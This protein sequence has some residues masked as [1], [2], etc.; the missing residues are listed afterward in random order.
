MHNCT[1]AFDRGVQRRE[2]RG[3]RCKVICTTLLSLLILAVPVYSRWNND[4]AQRR[5]AIYSGYTRQVRIREVRC[6]VPF[7]RRRRGREMYPSGIRLLY[8]AWV[9][10]SASVLVKQRRRRGNG[11][12]DT[13]DESKSRRPTR[14]KFNQTT[15]A[16]EQY[17]YLGASTNLGSPEDGS[18]S[19]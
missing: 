12:R 8:Q 2:R 4:S 7:S 18:F 13:L 10:P 19:S 9:G 6:D 16:Y 1:V 15:T 14:C 3:R 5:I 17:T 11:A